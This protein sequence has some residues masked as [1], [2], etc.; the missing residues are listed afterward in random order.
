MKTLYIAM[1]LVAVAVSCTTPA[2]ITARPDPN[3]STSGTLGSVKATDGVRPL[4]GNG[5]PD[6]ARGKRD[7]V[8]QH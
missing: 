4:T 8:R 5:I 2:P 3:T 6:S 7:T 1:A